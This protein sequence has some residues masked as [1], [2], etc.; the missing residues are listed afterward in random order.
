MGP[1]TDLNPYGLQCLSTV[2]IHIEISSFQFSFKATKP[3]FPSNKI[4]GRLP[5][6]A[7]ET[8]K[9]RGTDGDWDTGGDPASLEIPQG[10][11]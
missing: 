10:P 8:R 1:D 3:H 6:K 7:D 5:Y 9:V 2:T 4:L 11:K